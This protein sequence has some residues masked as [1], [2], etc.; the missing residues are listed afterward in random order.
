M[1]KR[2]KCPVAK[3]KVRTSLTFCKRNVIYQT[4]ESVF[5]QDIQTLT[6]GLKK[7]GAAEF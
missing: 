1:Q 3:V 4:P 5:Q 6:S 7:E 2:Q